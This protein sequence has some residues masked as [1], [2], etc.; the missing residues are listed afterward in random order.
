MP[1]SA[2]SS[3]EGKALKLLDFFFSEFWDSGRENVVRL[4]F[5]RVLMLWVSDVAE[6]RGMICYLL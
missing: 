2:Y 1:S 4:F 5:L 3:K 6:E